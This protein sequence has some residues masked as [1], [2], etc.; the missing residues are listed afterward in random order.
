MEEELVDVYDKYKVKTGKVIKREEKDFLKDNEY[1]ITVHCFIIDSSNRIL[2]T[3]RN[4]NQK[5]GGKWE[6]THG[7]LKSGETSILGIKRE[8]KE[9]IGVDVEINELKLVKTLIRKNKI[10]DIYILKKDIPINEFKY[11]DGEVIN[12]KYVTI[13]EFK[14][15]IENKECTFEKFEDT[16]FYNNEINVFLEE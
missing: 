5:R 13:D 3:Q 14:E 10:R 1:I 16:I 6:D 11:N 9:E 7:G 15:L 4:F 12:C 2:L 8:L